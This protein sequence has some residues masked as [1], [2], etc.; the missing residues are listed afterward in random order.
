VRVS[1]ILALALLGCGNTTTGSALVTFTGVASGPSDATGDPLSFT[2]G[3]GA[4]VTLTRAR[5]HL[6][7]VYLNQSVP[8]SGA[9]AV[10]CI[11]PGIYV[12]EVFGPL[13]I[14]LLSSSPEPFPTPGEGTETT[15]KTAEVWLSGGD[16]NAADDPTVILDV[17]GSATQDGQEYPFTGSVTIGSN[18]LPTTSNPAL[19]G[20][21][22]ICH[23]RIVT[24]ILVDLTPTNDGT[25]VLQIDP[26]AMFVALDFST[27]TQTSDDPPN[28]EIPD[29]TEGA[30]QAL[31]KGLTA[32]AGVYAFAW[33]T[34]P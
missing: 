11:S 21:N 29:T 20:A 2:N 8:S 9:A 22:P 18:R 28:Y 7:A 16:I 26:R 32:N 25:L 5:L 1:A 31:F 30:G 10:P 24:P 23:Q 3:F 4:D 17:A 33:Q 19:P 34:V 27:L 13:D 15:A 14:D 6:G 12:G